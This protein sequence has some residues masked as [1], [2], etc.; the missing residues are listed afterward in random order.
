MSVSIQHTHRENR[1]QGRD[2]KVMYHLRT[3][4]HRTSITNV[5]RLKI[6]AYSKG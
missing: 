2:L 3:A 1:H 4:I 5:C 6:S